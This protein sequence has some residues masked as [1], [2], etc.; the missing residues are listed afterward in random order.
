MISGCFLRIR[1]KKHPV[2]LS[3]QARYRQRP[4]GFMPM[5]MQPQSTATWPAPHG[6][7]RGSPCTAYRCAGWAAHP[8]YTAAYSGP[9]NLAVGGFNLDGVHRPV[10]SAVLFPMVFEKSR[11]RCRG[12][13]TRRKLPA[14]RGA[15]TRSGPSGQID[16]LHASVVHDP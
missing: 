11:S 10:L 15:R 14:L 12:P 9:A 13:R 3:G 8:G 2:G 16:F 1:L 6:T 5:I 4:S 7:G